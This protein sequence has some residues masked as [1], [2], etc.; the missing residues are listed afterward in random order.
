MG[1]WLT[2]PQYALEAGLREPGNAT[3]IPIGPLAVG[4]WDSTRSGPTVW[5][6]GAELRLT[7]GAERDLRIARARP[8]SDS[9]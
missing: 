5:S 3:S 6:T 8:C 9:W 4:V 1:G 7:A 2:W